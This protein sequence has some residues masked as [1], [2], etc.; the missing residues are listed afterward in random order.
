MLVRIQSSALLA[1]GCDARH[2]SFLNWWNRLDSCT[3]YLLSLGCDGRIQLSEGWRPGSTPGRDTVKLSDG[4][5]TACKAVFR[6]FDSHR[7]FFRPAADPDYIPCENDL[8]L[9]LSSLV[10]L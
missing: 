5:A 7:R 9:V 1:R 8:G 6:G 3:G 4:Q 10:G 2:S